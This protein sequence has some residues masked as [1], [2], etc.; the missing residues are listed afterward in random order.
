MK[1]IWNSRY[2]AM[3]LVASRE[4][5]DS[6]SI[7]TRHSGLRILHCH[8]C[9]LSR[10]WGSDLIPGPGVPHAKG[11][12]KMKKQSLE[13]YFWYLFLQMKRLVQWDCHFLEDN[14]SFTLRHLL[15]LSLYS[16][17][18]LVLLWY[19]YISIILFILLGTW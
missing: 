8:S 11:W 2:G 15:R 6:G 7:P 18:F 1:A 13:R 16:K 4:R 17:R 5:W 9:S 19:V 10:D 14:F 12:P 3:Q